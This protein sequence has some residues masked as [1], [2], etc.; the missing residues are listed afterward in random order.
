LFTNNVISSEANEKSRKLACH[1]VNLNIPIDTLPT[2]Q[3]SAGVIAL[4]E[5][6]YD[7]E[8]ILTVLSNIRE[9]AMF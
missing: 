5:K 6:I 7:R 8:L 4:F 1:M 2:L 9:D 3:I